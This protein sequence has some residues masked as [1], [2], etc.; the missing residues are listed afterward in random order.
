MLISSHEG[1]RVEIGMQGPWP[2]V[3][4]QSVART[5]ARPAGVTMQVRVVRASVEATARS[6]GGHRALRRREF[7]SWWCAGCTAC[8]SWIL[9]K[10]LVI[11]DMRLLDIRNECNDEPADH[12]AE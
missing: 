5:H 1:D 10:F 11:C 3:W 4:E 6:G 7:D 9:L 12:D 2:V 8:Q